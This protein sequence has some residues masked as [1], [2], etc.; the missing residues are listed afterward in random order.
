MKR[1]QKERKEDK[2]LLNHVHFVCG[3]PIFEWKGRNNYIKM[4]S[5]KIMK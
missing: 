4:Y 5:G 3:K 1:I 2:V